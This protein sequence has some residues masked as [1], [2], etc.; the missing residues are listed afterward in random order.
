[1]VEKSLTAATTVPPRSTEPRP[2]QQGDAPRVRAAA[3]L[4]GST[5]PCG[6]SVSNLRALAARLRAELGMPWPMRSVLIAVDGVPGGG[7][8]EVAEW[9][10]GQFEMH[11]VPILPYQGG[12][13]PAWRYR[14]L[15][16]SLDWTE[17][18]H[19]PTILYG[20]NVCGVLRAI[21]RT[22][23]FYVWVTG[24]DGPAK[25]EDG[26]VREVEAERKVDAVLQWRRRVAH[27]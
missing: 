14:D 3:P 11:A 18:V 7:Q 4:Q 27:P 15:A 22:A 23:S 8:Q 17:Q 19:L 20:E 12:T 16:R 9:L 26:S 2:V 1:V 25:A 10:A 6:Q 24:G 5:P 13:V 21:S